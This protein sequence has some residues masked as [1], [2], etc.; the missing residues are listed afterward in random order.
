[1]CLTLALV[2]CG[3]ALPPADYAGPLLYAH[4][5]LAL[6]HPP[7]EPAERPRWGLF[8][9]TEGAEAAALV[10]GTGRDFVPSFG[11]LRVFARPAP[12]QRP[13]GYAVL[14]LLAWDD[15]DGDGARGAAEPELG[16]TRTGLLYAHR[17]LAPGDTPWARAIPAGYHLLTLPP[18]CAAAI[19]GDGDCGV[20]LGAPCSGDEDCGGG[21][22]ADENP[23]WRTGYCVLP[24]DA[25]CR[26]ADGVRV[27]FR[28]GGQA[29]GYWLR[30]CQAAADCDQ[31]AP[32]FCDPALGACLPDDG[33]EL[34]LG[35]DAYR[36]AC[37]DGDGLADDDPGGGPPPPPND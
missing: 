17:D 37:D 36:S 34:E 4:P 18:P 10:P 26:P 33:F 7:G 2:G 29:A 28:R 3:D 30:A 5:E 12:A 22:C 25:A 31:T 24:A 11:P 16:G 9:V 27:V 6:T 19:R 21:Q 35:R 23:F 15:Q 20:P 14:A 8:V 32:H 13:G 1:M